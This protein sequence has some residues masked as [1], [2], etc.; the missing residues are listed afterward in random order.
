MKLEPGL[1]LDFTRSVGSLVAEY[2]RLARVFEGRGIDYCC[3]GGR[4]LAEAC[5]DRGLE[6]ASLVEAFRR[7]HTSQSSASEPISG[8]SS[9]RDVIRHI[10]EVHHPFLRR[11]LPRIAGLV[12]KCV[13]AHGSREPRFHDLRLEIERLAAELEQHMMKEEMVLFPLAI[14]LEQGDSDADAHCGGIE[15]PIRAMESEHEDVALAIGR[16]RALT[17]GFTPPEHACATWRELCRSLVEF[18]RDLHH[19]VHEENNI[20]HEKARAAAKRMVVN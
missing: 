11:E 15:N 12:R 6:R 20:L 3:G 19:H 5:A 16:L 2:P 17:D 7:D 10:L 18:E 9:I 1:D 4:S 13:A 14:A 8:Q